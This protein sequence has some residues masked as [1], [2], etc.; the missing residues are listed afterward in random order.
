VE[1][2]NLGQIIFMV[3]FI[4][5]LLIRFLRQRARRRPEDQV[6]GQA[7]AEEAPVRLRRQ[8]Q[9]AP[10]AAPSTPRASRGRAH[11]SPVPDVGAPL[12]GGHFIKKSLLESPR[13]VRRGIVL[14]TLLGPCRALDPPE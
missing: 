1:E 9:A 5:L 14:M 8:V 11:E 4:V 3:G 13:D 10:A 12:G 6:A 2:L 7:M